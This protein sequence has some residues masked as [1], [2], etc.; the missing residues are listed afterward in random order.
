M[1]ADRHA[2][3]RRCSLRSRRGIALAAALMFALI[4]SISA[5][6]LLFM[7]HA[8]ARQSY[9]FR[10]RAESRFASEA[11]VVWALQRLWPDT[12]YCGVPD[13]APGTFIPA[14]TVDVTMTTC[15]AGNAHRITSKV[16]Y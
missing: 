5:Y 12:A 10:K 15:G 16:T 11:G 6:V 8:T 4:A 13:P 1:V 9:I 2:E 14:T 3:D 7:A